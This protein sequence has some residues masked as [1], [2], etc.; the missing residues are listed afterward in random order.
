MT[1]PSSTSRSGP[2]NGNGVT[3]AFDYEF[4]ILDEDHLKVILADNA[5][6]E[7]V[8]NV[9][10]DYTVSGVGDDTGYITLDTAP[11]AGF[12]VTIL[13]NAPRDRP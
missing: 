4:R 2:Y 5:G 11:V 7:T 3:T 10:T 12:T 6:N 9:G 13:R 1:I 8:L